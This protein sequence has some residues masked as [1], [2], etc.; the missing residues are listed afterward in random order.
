MR[1]LTAIAAFAALLTAVSCGGGS[2]ATAP[3]ACAGLRKPGV[4]LAFAPAKAPTL[5]RA[6]CVGVQ[7]TAVIGP[8]SWGT[9]PRTMRR[10]NSNLAAWQKRSLLYACN[11][12]GLAGFGLDW[13]RA[14]HPG[15]IV[16]SQSGAEIHPQQHPTWVLLNFTSNKYRNAW[17][18][19]VSK[20]LAAGGW[21]GVDVVDAGNDPDWSQIPIDPSTG[22]PMTERQRRFDLAA[23]L[24]LVRAV[25]KLRGGYSVLAANGPPSVFD[26]AQVNSTDTVTT[27]VGFA[28]LSGQAWNT[29][30]AYYQ[31]AGDSEVGT[32]IP[33]RG[34]LSR[35]Q[36]LY[37]LAGFLL[38]AIPRDSAYIA[39]ARPDLPL[40]AIQ[41][42]AP[43]GSP[44]T[45][46][47]PVWVRTYPNAVVAVN[48]SDV[49]GSVEMGAAG[50][51][52]MGPESAAIETGG[53]LLTTG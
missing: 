20:S 18:V 2:G 12:C 5:D 44:A 49:A 14:H 33:D 19:H 41:P 30:L 16:H 37:G 31:Q 6:R 50:R 48:P 23:A 24:A 29:E 45:A 7:Y 38:V 25:L 11:G 22:K 53:H 28:R 35:P 1:S 34:P 4:S 21:T 39:P 40:Y 42:G 46:V 10:A 36:L 27:G 8:Q 51:V 3:R 32:F 26:F 17:A 43:P 47:G 13:V 52:T 9:L 15:W